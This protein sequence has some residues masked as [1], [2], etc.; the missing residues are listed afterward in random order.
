MEDCTKRTPR[1]A[2]S[3]GSI[4]RCKATIKSFF[5]LSEKWPANL[6]EASH[7]SVLV[8]CGGSKGLIL[9]PR[10]D[11]LWRRA[12]VRQRVACFRSPVCLCQQWISKWGRWPAKRLTEQVSPVRVR[13]EDEKYTF[14]WTDWSESDRSDGV[15]RFL[16]E[17]GSVLHFLCF[18]IG[19]QFLLSGSEEYLSGGLRELSPWVHIQGCYILGAGRGIQEPSPWSLSRTRTRS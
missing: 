12:G 5:A 16:I 6:P 2:S 19:C 4:S 11:F 1:L 14:S 3:C 17:D 10:I 18:C 9:P 13:P 7:V 8:D 15:S